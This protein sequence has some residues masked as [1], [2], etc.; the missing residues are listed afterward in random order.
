MGAIHANRI[1][2]SEFGGRGT[3][4]RFGLSRKFK[5]LLYPLPTSQV[6]QK[7]RKENIYYGLENCYLGPPRLL[8]GPPNW[9]KCP[10]KNV[11]LRVWR[12]NWISVRSWRKERKHKIASIG[13]HHM[14]M[15]RKFS[16]PRHRILVSVIAKRNYW[17]SYCRYRNYPI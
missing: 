3:Q 7:K 10:Y 14:R 16:S 13:R 17:H 4:S 9:L 11:S 1:D 2:N 5:N 15:N 6:A 12:R 8:R